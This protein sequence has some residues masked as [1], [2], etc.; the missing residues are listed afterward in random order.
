VN[1][2]LGLG[3]D[4]I[5]ILLVASSLQAKHIA[6]RQAQASNGTYGQKATTIHGVT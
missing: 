5:I 3:F 2:T 1:H 4:E 6:E